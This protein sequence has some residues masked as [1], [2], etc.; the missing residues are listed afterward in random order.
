MIPKSG[1]CHQS[2]RLTPQASII[3][4]CQPSFITSIPHL[5]FRNGFASTVGSWAA[6]LSSC[7][8]F[9]APG[10]AVLEG[11][12]ALEI[13]GGFVSVRTSSIRVGDPGNCVR[14]ALRAF[15]HPTFHNWCLCIS[16]Q[17]GRRHRSRAGVHSIWRG[18]LLLC[19][20]LAAILA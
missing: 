9:D 12:V 3:A 8:C 6:I 17:T 10:H 11:E 5:R 4:Q 1:V 2:R 18:K 20:R 13:K 14:G 16:P 15:S 19:H 7:L